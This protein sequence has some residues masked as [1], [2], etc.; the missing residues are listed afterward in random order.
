MANP[1]FKDGALNRDPHGA[2]K[3]ATFKHG[4]AQTIKRTALPRKK[5]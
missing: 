4:P 2:P 1:Y 3:V 5:G